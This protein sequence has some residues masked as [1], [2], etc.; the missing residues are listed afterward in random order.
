MAKT[1][2]YLTL[3]GVSGAKK[4]IRLY[5]S[6]FGAKESSRMPYTKEIGKE[7]GFPKDF[8]YENSTM[9]AEIDI[10]G[11]TIYLAD[12]LGFGEEKAP[13]RGLGKVEIYLELDSKESFDRI[14]EKASKRRGFKILMPAELTFWGS[15]F[16]RFIDSKKVSW[17][18]AYT[19]PQK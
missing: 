3:K 4:A 12:D 14:W 13:R 17:Q 5:K 1:I 11:A 7:Y 15:W 18:I 2:P 8:D 10:E 19:P 9:H 6:V 16:A